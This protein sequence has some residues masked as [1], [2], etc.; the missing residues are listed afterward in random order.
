MRSSAAASDAPAA[1]REQGPRER[2]S[3][4]G[5]AG[6]YPSDRQRACKPARAPPGH[7]R[8]GRRRAGGRLG[9]VGLVGFAPCQPSSA[10]ACAHPR[11]TARSSSRP[12]PVASTS[13]ARRGET[14]EVL[15]KVLPLA[16]SLSQAARG[17]SSTCASAT[18]A[19]SSRSATSTTARTAAGAWTRSPDRSHRGAVRV[20]RAALA[21]LAL[22]AV[23]S[24]AGGLSACGADDEPS[25]DIPR[26]S[27]D[28][29]IP[30]ATTRLPPDTTTTPRRRR[31][32]PRRCSRRRR[33]PP[34]APP[35]V[36]A[37][38]VAPAG[39]DDRR[40]RRRPRTGGQPTT[41]GAQ[42]GDADFQNFCRENP[43]AGRGC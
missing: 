11:P 12:S 20:R 16:P 8:P 30:T 38:P 17:R 31:R 32:T 23:L 10:T 19:T 21:R 41:G 13:T 4:H 37:P 28:L 2:C 26:T 14:L 36:V 9:R 39:V 22:L 1:R 40:R 33:R 6:L 15:G 34:S 43:G 29:T 7:G 42:P 5:R 25:S 18:G 27:P 35:P 3:P 24:L